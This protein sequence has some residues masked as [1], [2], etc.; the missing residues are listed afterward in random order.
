MASSNSFAAYALNYGFAASSWDTQPIWIS[1]HIADPGTTG[2]DELSNA[3]YSRETSTFGAISTA[4]SVMTNNSVITFNTDGNGETVTY[5]GAWY[6]VSAGTFLFGGAL[7]TSFAYNNA[8][9][10]VFAEGALKLRAT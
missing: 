6:G 5:A 7:G 3:T 9:T 1:L 8:V 4:T 2:A 10:P